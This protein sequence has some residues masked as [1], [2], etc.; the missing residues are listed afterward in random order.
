MMSVF[1]TANLTAN[2]LRNKKMKLQIKNQTK[3]AKAKDTTLSSNKVVELL[4]KQMKNEHN[5]V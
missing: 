5:K 3:K 1:L 4:I 2:D